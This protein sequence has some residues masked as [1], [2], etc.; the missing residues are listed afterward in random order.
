MREFLGSPLYLFG[1]ISLK[2]L[3]DYQNGL[4]ICATA[5]YKKET[6]YCE[7]SPVVHMLCSELFYFIYKI[8]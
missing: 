5:D 3:T 1:L 2:L 4:N 6:L 8:I 7:K